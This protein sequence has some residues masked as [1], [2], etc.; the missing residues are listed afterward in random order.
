MPVN[1]FSQQVNFI[2]AALSGAERIYEIMEE[3]EELD[4]AP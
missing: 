3:P 2:M 1:Q 4:R